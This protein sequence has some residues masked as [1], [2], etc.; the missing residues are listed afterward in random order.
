MNIRKKTIIIKNEPIEFVNS[1][2]RYALENA[3]SY[4]LQVKDFIYSNEFSHIDVGITIIGTVES[5]LLDLDPFIEYDKELEAT[6]DMFNDSEEIKEIF[7][8]DLIFSDKKKHVEEMNETIIGYLNPGTKVNLKFQAELLNVATYKNTSDACP[9]NIWHTYK[10]ND[11]FPETIKLKIE[12]FSKILNID[13]YFKNIYLN[14]IEYIN[15][16][17]NKINLDD[18]DDIIIINDE[19]NC[20]ITF[21]NTSWT[22]Q[23][24]IMSQISKSKETKSIKNELFPE[25]IFDKFSIDEEQ[26]QMN[27]VIF[28]V[29][30][31]KPNKNIKELTIKELIKCFNSFTITLQKIINTL[32]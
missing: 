17:I 12:F 8:K 27:K 20:T 6:I 31:V 25:N 21:N 22:L 23:N 2:R 32:F 15:K 1:L 16:L 28:L 19:Y 3:R 13:N 11:D 4:K 10:G 5:L 9:F 24:I 26:L 18:N 14:M 29:Y 7:I 30:S